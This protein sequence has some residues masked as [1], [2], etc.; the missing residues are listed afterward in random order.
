MTVDAMTE[1]RYSA[2]DRIIQQGEPGNSFY[3]IRYGEVAVSISEQESPS[4][5]GGKSKGWEKEVTKLTQDCEEG[6]LHCD[7]PVIHSLGNFFHTKGMARPNRLECIGRSN[8]S[9]IFFEDN[10]PNEYTTEN[11]RQFE[12][13]FAGSSW[14]TLQAMGMVFLTESDI[15]RVVIIMHYIRFIC[16]L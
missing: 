15:F 13:I 12:T 1:V 8:Y 11:A 16:S 9:I 14:N 3:M 10:S 7:F 4:K 2:G 5:T 6:R